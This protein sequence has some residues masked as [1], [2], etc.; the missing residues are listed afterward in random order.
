M[1]TFI[2]IKQDNILLFF[3]IF[4]FFSF[5]DFNFGLL[6]VEYFELFKHI[7]LDLLMRF[8]GIHFFEKKK[9]LF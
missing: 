9:T 4:F 1:I 5:R 7:V 6:C 2:I 3:K 8:M